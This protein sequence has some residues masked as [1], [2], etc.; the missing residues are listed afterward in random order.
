[1]R[2]IC[3]VGRAVLSTRITLA[4]VVF[5]CASGA[6]TAAIP[7][8]TLVGSYAL[9]AGAGP[10]AVLGD[11][12]LLVMQGSTILRQT[13][14]NGGTFAALGSVQA[15]LISTFGASFVSVSRDG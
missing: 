1:M 6:A 13:A 9:P 8:Y 12:S 3:H 7:P 15:S 14:V 10:S 2:T 5:A 4:A 11:G